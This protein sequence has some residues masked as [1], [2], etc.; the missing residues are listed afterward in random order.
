MPLW[1]FL[2]LG[3]IFLAVLFLPPLVAAYIDFQ[4]E[5]T[6]TPVPSGPD[7]ERPRRGEGGRG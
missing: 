6:R 2:M 7:T 4:R 5:E 1:P 3:G